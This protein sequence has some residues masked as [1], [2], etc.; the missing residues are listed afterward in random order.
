MKKLL[1]F[2]ADY[3]RHTDIILIVFCLAA[4]GISVAALAAMARSG[5]VDTSGLPY[6]TALVQLAA[7]GAGVCVAMLLSKLD[8]H[9]MAKLWKIHAPL[10]VALVVLT[11]FIGITV[12]EADDKAW[13]SLP[14]GLSF[15]PA[16]VLKI[17]FVITFAF[18]LSVVK[19][20]I[21]SL[22]NVLL[23]GAHAA[24]P[25]LLVH[26]QG[27]DGTA[28]VFAFIFLSMSFVAGLSW[29]YLLGAAAALAAA[30]PLVWIYVMNEDQRQRIEM[31]VTGNLDP[32]GIGYQQWHG[33][34]SIG[35]G[36]LLGTGLFGGEHRYV[37]AMRNDFIFAFLGEAMGF[38]GCLIVILLLLGICS[39]ILW[40]S[41][42]AQDDLGRYICIGIF[43]MIAFQSILNI[44]MCLSMLPV[45]GVTL[46]FFS[47]GG[48]SAAAL[49]LGIGVV[50]S[51]YMHSRR[52]LF[53]D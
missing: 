22:R 8:Y 41:H 1:H 28:M 10:C 2:A 19:E 48:T 49:Y 4:S 44:G 34:L 31:I 46:P 13:I 33:L 18:H 53:M 50:L 6:K 27:D 45:I 40:T 16:E 38:V 14:L 24:L 3:L 47:A 39:R 42:L 15:Q 51:V 20:E 5:Y 29:R 12:G 17:S 32:S 25:V 9:T 7:S 37:P 52:H 26:L 43:A 30:A 23:L 36:Q 11:F 35:S 21:N